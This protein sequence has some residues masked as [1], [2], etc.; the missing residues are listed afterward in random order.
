M[1][2]L[3][4]LFA[5]K[6]LDQEPVKLLDGAVTLYKR[7]NSHQWQCR[8]KLS[9]GAW[10][11]A[12]TGSDQLAEAT[13][14]AIAV[15]ETVKVKLASDLAIK[16]RTFRQL[17]TQELA[18]AARVVHA[19]PN[20]RTHA[21]YIH[22]FTKY[23]IP[24]FGAY[25]IN[26][27]TQE[28]V[29]DYVAWRISQMGKEPKSYTQRRHAGLYKRVIQHAR[30]QGLI[31]QNRTV[32]LLE[33]AGEKP[34]ARPAFNQQE[35]NYLLE[36][37]RDWERFGRNQR[38]N[39]MRRLCRVYVEFLL[40]T[41]IRQGTE[42]MPIR[43]KSLQWH[44]IGEQRYLR[45]W[46]SGKTGPRYLIAKHFVVEALERLIKWQA[47]PYPNLDAVIQAKLDRR[48]FVFP[49]GDAPHSLD[50]VFERLMIESNLLKDATGKNRT[51]YSLRHTYATFRLADGIDIHTLAKQ[52]GTSVGMIER[53]YSKLTLM[54]SAERLAG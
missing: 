8:F 52:M 48:V 17:A 13:T 43:W 33:V 12:S 46:V 20:K 26:D 35:V 31:H 19:N 24:F 28:V 21:D 4:F 18:A 40:G 7:P 41:G 27:I 36:Y 44:W 14:Q 54:M 51:L 3:S 9:T 38:S 23:L 49:A 10:H 2:N 53:H 39:H 22:I 34:E 5:A 29:D 15:Y 16:T 42:S 11:S 47:L 45:V 1:N 50:S 6:T 32:P 37:M 25:Q 30:A